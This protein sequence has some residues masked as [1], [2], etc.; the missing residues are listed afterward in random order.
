MSPFLRL[1]ENEIQVCALLFLAIVYIF[2]I[3]WIMRFQPARERTL[4]AGSQGRG[5]AYSLLSVSLPMSMEAARK[6]PGFYAQFVILH[7]GVAAAVAA[8]FIILSP[9]SP[10]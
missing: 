7:L 5:I 3:L 1:L 9:V 10:G 8:T 2:R 6:K 4:P